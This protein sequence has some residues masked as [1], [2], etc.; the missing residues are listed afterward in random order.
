MIKNCSKKSNF[1]TRGNQESVS[2]AHRGTDDVSEFAK[3]VMKARNN[4][5]YDLAQVAEYAVEYLSEE[6]PE[7]KDEVDKCK[8]AEEDE[9]AVTG[10]TYA[11]AAGTMAG[12]AIAGAGASSL[13]GGMAS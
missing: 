6:Y 1:S 13:M 4:D 5:D 3:N 7:V 10:A 12:T 8:K 11:A 2:R 9:A